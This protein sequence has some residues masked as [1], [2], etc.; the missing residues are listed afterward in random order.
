MVKGKSEN[1]GYD[2]VEIAEVPRGR[3]GK[4]HSTV[5]NILADVAGLKDGSALRVPLDSFGRVKL[6]NVRAAIGRAAKQRD[7]SIM[8]TSNAKHLF[9]WRGDDKIARKARQ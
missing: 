7:L 9:I 6:A 5:E 1:N 8:T 3:R 4:H 2:T